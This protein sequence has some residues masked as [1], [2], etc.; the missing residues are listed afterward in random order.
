MLQE[1][2]GFIVTLKLCLNLCSCQWVKPKRSL[3]NNRIP[4]GRSSRPEVFC[5]KGVLLKKRLRH[6]FF[7]VNFAKFLRTPFLAASELYRSYYIY[8]FSRSNKLQQR[9]PK[10]ELA[11]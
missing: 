5:K 4:I 1:E 10:Y 3:I 11:S 9:L 2:N 8:I 6:R 7:P